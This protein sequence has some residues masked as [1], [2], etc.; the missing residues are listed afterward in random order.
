VT[1]DLNVNI[2]ASEFKADPF[3]LYRRL[4]ELAPVYRVKLPDRQM[5]WLVTRY[6]DVV[7]VL[8]DERFAKDV[9]RVLSKE[10]LVAHAAGSPH[11]QP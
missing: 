3:P 8:T 7:T 5:A 1:V 9:F 11:A 2:A 10:Q 4:R 6:D